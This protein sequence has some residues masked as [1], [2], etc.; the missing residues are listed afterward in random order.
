VR[1]EKKK[2][3]PDIRKVRKKIQ[4]AEIKVFIKNNT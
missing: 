4:K 1:G 2:G 3:K